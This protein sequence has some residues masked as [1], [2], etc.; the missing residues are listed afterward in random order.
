M[1][2]QN[3]GNANLIFPSF[4]IIL[5]D[6]ILFYKTVS[7]YNFFSFEHRLSFLLNSAGAESDISNAI[8]NGILYLEDPV[9][10]EWRPHFFM[11]TSNRMYYA[12]EEENRDEDD[13]NEDTTTQP[14]EVIFSFF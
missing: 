5:S 1:M 13:D 9:D 4:L 11:L 6:I 8:K 2:T 14:R 3:L 12:E 7:T 10:H